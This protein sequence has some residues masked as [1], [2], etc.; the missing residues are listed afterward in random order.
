MVLRARRP[1]EAKGRCFAARS[2][3]LCLKT[4]MLALQPRAFLR[5][6]RSAGLSNRLHPASTSVSLLLAALWNCPESF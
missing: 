2:E 4:R 5:C 3:P 1:H 6:P